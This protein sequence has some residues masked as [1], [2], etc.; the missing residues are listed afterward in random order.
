MLDR[1]GSGQEKERQASGQYPKGGTAWQE[2]SVPSVELKLEYAA[3][4]KR[5]S[6]LQKE[7]QLNRTGNLKQLEKQFLDDAFR[8]DPVGQFLIGLE[9]AK[10]VIQENPAVPSRDVSVG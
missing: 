10:L 4:K 1:R 5:A 2:E 3:L 6:Q 7:H 9:L 8:P